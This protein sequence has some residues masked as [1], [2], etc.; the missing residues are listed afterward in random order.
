MNNKI[1]L[2]LK[3]ASLLI[4]GFLSGAI[5]GFREGSKAFYIVES[6]PKGT[7]AMANLRQLE[8]GNTEPIKTF[9]NLDINQGLYHYSLAQDQWWFPLYKN[10]LISGYSYN[11]ELVQKLANYRKQYPGPSDDPAIF[12]KI[13][14]G[15]EEYSDEYLDMA[16]SHR[17]RLNRIQQTI[18][19]FAKE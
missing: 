11:S 6:L 14:V 9:L 17:D 13:P 5:F 18:N 3:I 2:V 10:G 19:R 4:I 7:I 15:K 12:D 8:K 16:Q 1:L